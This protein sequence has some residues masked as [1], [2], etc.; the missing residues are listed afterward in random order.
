[1]NQPVIKS[2][3]IIGAAPCP[4]QISTSGKFNNGETAAKDYTQKQAY[5]QPG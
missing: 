5:P 4:R 3:G 2:G 1:M